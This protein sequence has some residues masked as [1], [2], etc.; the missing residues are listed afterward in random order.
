MALA[1]GAAAAVLLVLSSGGARPSI[2]Q[3]QS[4]GVTAGAIRTYSTISSIGVEWDI[5]GDADHDSISTVEFRAAGTSPWR[6]ALPLD[7]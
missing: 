1:G 7:L 3:A 2:L 5:A 6:S 4:S